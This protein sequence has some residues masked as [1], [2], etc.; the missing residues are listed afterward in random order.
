[1]GMLALVLLLRVKIANSIPGRSGGRIFF[2]KVNFVCRLLVGVRYRIGTQKTPVILPKVQMAGYTSKHA[3]TLDPTK[4][5]WAD[6][7]ALQA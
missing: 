4:S 5:E 3:Y 1:M 2:S 7:A 6:Y